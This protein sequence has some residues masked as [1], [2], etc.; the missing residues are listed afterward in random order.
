[1]SRRC[2]LTGKGVLT[3]NKVSHSNRKSRRTFRPNLQNITLSSDILGQK[4]SLRVAANT[5]RTVDING[6]LDAFLLSHA[7][8]DL[9]VKSISLKNKIKKALATKSQITA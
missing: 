7:D 2:E 4:F 5:I 6:G 3:G 9:T 8:K 1:M